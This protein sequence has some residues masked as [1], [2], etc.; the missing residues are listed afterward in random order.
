MANGVG[1][2]FFEHAEGSGGDF[3]VNSVIDARDDRHGDTR[4]RGH[5]ARF[6]FNGP[7]EIAVVQTWRTQARRNASHHCDAQIDLP[8]GR[9]E[10]IDNISGRLEFAEPTDG[11]PEIQL[12]AGEQLT[13]LVVQL[14]CD[15]GALFFTH[16][17]DALGQGGVQI[18]VVWKGQLH[19]RTF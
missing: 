1:Q 14:A 17:L 10:P 16:L 15:S 13:Q 11:G 6:I 19:V 18:D 2:R 12:D 5:A 8:D 3:R 7:A 9:L 4:H